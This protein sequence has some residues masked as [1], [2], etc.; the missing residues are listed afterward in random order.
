MP[1]GKHINHSYYGTWNV[2]FAAED[3]V[4]VYD[5]HVGKWLEPITASDGLLQYPALLVYQDQ[6]TQNVWIVTPDYVFIYDHNSHWMSKEALPREPEFSGHYSLGITSGNVIITSA[7]TE[8]PQNYSAVFNKGTG[9]FDAW[10]AD[11]VLAIN[12]QEYE[13]IDNIS[14]VFGSFPETLPVQNL[15]GGN[16]DSDGNL[17][18]DG[19]PIRSGTSMSTLSGEAESGELFLGTHG[20][21]VFHRELRG[22]DFEQLPYGLL[23]PD[24][25]CM[26]FDED[27]LIIG[28]RAGLTMMNGFDARYDEALQAPV[29]DYSFVSAVD[30]QKEKL[31]ISGRGGVFKKRAGT[32]VWERIISKKDLLSE[33]IYSLASGNDGNLLVATERN[34]YLYHESGLYLASIFESDLNWPVF[35]IKYSDNRYYIS[36]LYG[37]YVYDELKNKMLARIN[38]HAEVQSPMTSAAVDPVY[39]SV[40]VDSILWASTH[41]GLI[42]IDLINNQGKD[43]LSPGSPFQPRGLD[44]I[45]GKVWVG[46]TSGLYSFEPQTAAWR[47]Y[48]QND[49]LISNF[50]T[51]LV[52]K[53]NYIWLGTNLG[54]TRI[55]WR[56]LY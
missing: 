5:H 17:R 10:G 28:S 44:V 18:L 9:A 30:Q 36:T 26:T 8:D 52:A 19:Y 42:Q 20:M 47:H 54:L 13:K 14:Q 22:G 7:R 21:G 32:G 23:S 3:G 48:T 11:S 4:L 37:L 16:F 6:T 24:V 15:S 50:V 35:D 31:F 56:N 46:S 29:Y 1:S 51:D 55:N 12:W 45:G 25:M 39:E 41:R 27:E 34:A 49:G 43:Y 40:V 53:E 33:R 38:S 2:Y